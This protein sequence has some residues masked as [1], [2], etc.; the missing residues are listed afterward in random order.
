MTEKKNRVY[1][2]EFKLEALQL[3][4]TS[5]KSATQIEQELGITTGLLLKWRNRYEIKNTAGE[6][7]H[8]E[9]NELESAKK[10]IRRL[11][12]EIMEIAE[13]REIL[14]KVVNIFSRTGA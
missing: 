13:E 1:P 10:E 4:R 2:E 5:K 7:E 11:E 12:R 6:K 3:L 14:K 9:I 8:L